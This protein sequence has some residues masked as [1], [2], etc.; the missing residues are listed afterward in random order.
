MERF[1]YHLRCAIF[2]VLFLTALLCSHAVC[3]LACRE[4]FSMFLCGE[5]NEYLWSILGG[6]TKMLAGARLWNC[7]K[8]FPIRLLSI[9]RDY[10]VPN[11]AE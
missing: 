9:E 8:D 2:D 10:G 1:G 3:Y 11:F 5:S 6:G 7:P 4:E